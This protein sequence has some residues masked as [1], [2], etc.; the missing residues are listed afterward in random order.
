MDSLDYDFDEEAPRYRKKSRK[1]HVRSDHKHEY[2]NVC[3]DAHTETRT[4]DGVFPSYHIA[5]R[6][7]ICGRL[8]DVKTWATREIPKEMPLYEVADFWELFQMKMLPD[9]M[10]VR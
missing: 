7:K 10:R 1:R 6:C 2:E 4:R 9:G 8:Y 3:V 5:T